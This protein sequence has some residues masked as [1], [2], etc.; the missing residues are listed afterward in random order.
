[1]KVGSLE[2]SEPERRFLQVGQTDPGNPNSAEASFQ[3]FTTLQVARTLERPQV[4]EIPDRIDPDSPSLFYLMERTGRGKDSKLA[5]ELPQKTGKN[6]KPALWIDW[7]ELDGPVENKPNAGAANPRPP[8][9]KAIRCAG[10]PREK[11]RA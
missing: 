1:M 8:R 2:D 6:P 10:L 5:A 11:A 7:L 9:F 4:L 3:P